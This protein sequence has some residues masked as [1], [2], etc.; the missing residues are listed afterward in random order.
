M[1]RPIGRLGDV[2]D[3]LPEV[4]SGGRW[5]FGPEMCS[6]APE[7][8]ENWCLQH[9]RPPPRPCTLAVLGGVCLTGCTAKVRHRRPEYWS[10]GRSFLG[11]ELGA[12]GSDSDGNPCFRIGRC[13]GSRVGELGTPNSG[14]STK[15]A[16]QAPMFVKIR[17][18]RAQIS[19]STRWTGHARPLDRPSADSSLPDPRSI[20]GIG[21]QQTLVE[22]G[23]KSADSRHSR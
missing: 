18:L 15:D 3:R 12:H 16:P 20:A 11:P 10:R 4:R 14:F 19:E 22:S 23:P 7:F 6:Q 8:A 17:S 13:W 2:R 5:E 1:V 9:D 21:F